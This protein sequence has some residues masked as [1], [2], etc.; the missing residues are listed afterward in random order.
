MALFCS[1]P[2]NS[3]IP[4][5]PSDKGGKQLPISEAEEAQNEWW[6]YVPVKFLFVIVIK[7]ET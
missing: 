2:R 3:K 5:D 4:E 7:M 6:S 1:Q